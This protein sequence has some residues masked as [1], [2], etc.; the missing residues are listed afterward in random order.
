MAPMQSSSGMRFLRRVSYSRCSHGAWRI[1]TSVSERSYRSSSSATLAAADRASASVQPLSVVLARKPWIRVLSP[2]KAAGSG[3][4]VIA[5]AP[6][7]MQRQRGSF[8]CGDFIDDEEFGAGLCRRAMRR[9]A[10][11]GDLVTHP[12]PQLERSAI[13]KFGIEFAVDD[14]QHVAEVD[15][16]GPE[17]F[18]AVAPRIAIREE[19]DAGFERAIAHAA[20]ADVGDVKAGAAELHIN[21][22]SASYGGLHLGSDR[23]GRLNYRSPE[24]QGRTRAALRLQ[25]VDAVAVAGKQLDPA[26]RQGL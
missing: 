2:S 12:R 21:S 3:C 13:T 24:F 10:A 19:V 16:R 6:F 23:R 25:Q 18:P 17:D 22:S 1:S 9:I 26:V 7:V 15:N 4:V 20:E 11:F 8:R 14:I 5:T